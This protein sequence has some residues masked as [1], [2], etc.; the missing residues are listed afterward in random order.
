MNRIAGILCTGIFILTACDSGAPPDN[1]TPPPAEKSILELMTAVI[2]P[3]TDTLWGAYDPQTE[4]EWQSLDEA[5]VVVIDT[6]EAIRDGGS[7]P[8]DD[9]WAATPGFQAYID[10][11]IDA[12]R[13]MQSAIVARDAD[14]LL[15]AGDALY[16][17]CET[18]HL[19]FNPAVQGPAN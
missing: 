12:A 17:P 13:L 18:C 19:D 16:Q 6:F 15:T 1:A 2:T 8:N 9:T 5:A 4:E 10:E 11:E 7:G 14:A 3:A